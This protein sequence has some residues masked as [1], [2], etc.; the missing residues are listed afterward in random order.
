MSTIQ[1]N[2]HGGTMNRNAD[3]YP[4]NDDMTDIISILTRIDDNGVEFQALRNASTAFEFTTTD[5]FLASCQA[6]LS[7]YRTAR[8]LAT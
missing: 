8:P 6:W 4:S 2:G 7:G 1:I 5:E 3:D